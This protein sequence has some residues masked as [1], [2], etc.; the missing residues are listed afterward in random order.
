[1]GYP[2]TAY[3]FPLIRR[4][5]PRDALV[6]AMSHIDRLLTLYFFRPWLRRPGLAFEP[7]VPILMYHSVSDDPERG[8]LGY[9]R[10]A[11]P[12]ERLREQKRLLNENGYAVLN[13]SEALRQLEA[14]PPATDR[15]VVLTLDDGYYDFMTNAWPI[16][17]ESA[18]EAII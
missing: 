1:M 4:T 8:V 13:I 12:P 11:T 15:H 17:A 16:L 5:F 6:S 2:G 14:K 9:Y 10:T 18:R 7:A 3:Q